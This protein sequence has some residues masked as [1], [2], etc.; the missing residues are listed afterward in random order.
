LSGAGRAGTRKAKTSETAAMAA[1]ARNTAA[2]DWIHRK[3]NTTGITTA[4]MW[5]MVKLTPALEAMSAGS[6]IFW[7]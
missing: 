3:P 6:A 7:K 4:T 2:D 1:P 5:L